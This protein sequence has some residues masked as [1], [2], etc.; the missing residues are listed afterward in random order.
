MELF[1]I[2][3]FMLGSVG[4]GIL[5]GILLIIGMLKLEFNLLK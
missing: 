5:G 2:F 3:V 1:M 4:G